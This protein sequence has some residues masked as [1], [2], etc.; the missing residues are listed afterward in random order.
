MFVFS[1]LWRSA[2]GDADFG[3]DMKQLYEVLDVGVAVLLGFE[4]GRAA[5]THVAALEVLKHFVVDEA[6]VELLGRLE[7]L[8]RTQLLAEAHL[9]AEAKRG[10]HLSV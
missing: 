7:K 3:F 6:V 8:A 9:Y 1:P 4:G 5:Q 2:E 10:Q